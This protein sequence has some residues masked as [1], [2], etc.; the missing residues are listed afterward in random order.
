MEPQNTLK[1]FEVIVCVWK[2]KKDKII[3][4]LQF[5]FLMIIDTFVVVVMYMCVCMFVMCTL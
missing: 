4:D 2:N 5:L 3:L 1:V